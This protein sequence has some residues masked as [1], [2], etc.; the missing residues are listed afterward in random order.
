MA[1]RVFA[2]V[3]GLLALTAFQGAV[4]C[5]DD[6]A[7]S[8]FAEGD[9][10]AAGAGGED[11][12]DADAEAG[13]DPTLGGPCNDLEQCDDGIDCTSDRCDLEIQRC[14]FEPDPAVCADDIHCDGAEV[15]E[16]GLGCRE[17]E[18]VSCSDG[19]SCTIDRCVEATQ[20]CETLPRDADGDGDPVW[21]C[22]GGD[23]DDTDPEV[24]SAA[25][26]RCGNSRDDDCDGEADEADCVAPAHDLCSDAL[27]LSAS[28]THVLSL[29]G[30]SYDYPVSCQSSSTPYRDVVVA[31]VV[32]GPDPADVDVTVT[33][34]SGKLS[35]ASAEQCGDPSTETACAAGYS[36]SSGISVSRLRLRA[37]EPGAY[38]IY[39]SGT[40][41]GNVAL[42]VR[43]E[44]PSDAPSNE[45]C[46]TALPL[47]PDEH[48]SVSLVGLTPDVKSACNDAV[49]DLFYT[50]ELLEP[51]DVTLRAVPFDTNG[52]PVL[53][54]RSE[55]CTAEGDEIT[56]RQTSPAELY[57][58]ALAAGTYTVA[59][60]GTGPSDLDLVLELDPPST[61]PPGEGCADAVGLE[62]GTN[63]VD[64]AGRVDAVQIGCLV[65]APD[66]SYTL[67]LGDDSDVLLVA[68]LSEDDT[69]ALL[70][71]DAPCSSEA[72]ELACEAS[73]DTP[74]RVAGYGLSAGSYRVVAESA[75]GTPIALDVFERPA[76]P[77]TYV[78]FADECASAITIPATGGRFEGNTASQFADYDAG[79]DAAGN[80]TGG[81]PEQMLRLELDEERRVILDMHGSEYKTL[82]SVRK[83]P[84][85]PGTEVELGCSAGTSANRSFLDL[86][87]PAGTYFVQ[88]D[89]YDGAS[90]LWTLDVYLEPP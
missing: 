71:A 18:P 32:P 30:A 64:F 49:G 60:S 11:G 28:G 5:G 14:R 17:G 62:S 25:L 13:I 48:Q 9:A 85:C 65:G 35:L 19:D 57:A 22:E 77:A 83:G 52:S 33:S 36:G 63:D 41:E 88:I 76:T 1:G 69:A 78:A 21:N 15:C 29:A 81:A 80:D 26:E 16:P 24:S 20:S 7:A 56:C 84:A 79:C 61:K 74:L 40:R 45:T 67:E 70:I 12:T 86:T 75:L 37:L 51:S 90:G 10:G 23:C 42:S 8:P 72:D 68:R 47:L 55:A 54:L 89:G 39:V 46:G 27:E 82:L 50:F 66:A 58:R 73:N 6:T 43:F 38:P 53:S 2:R 34:P 44:A 87:L 3:V 31:V 4:A 59:V